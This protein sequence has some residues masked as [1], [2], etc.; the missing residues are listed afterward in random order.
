MRDMQHYLSNMTVDQVQE[1]MALLVE[2]HEVL[3]EPY[4]AR[5]LAW[6]DRE[7][8]RVGGRDR[9]SVV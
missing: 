3:G 1:Y 7:L 8:D 6:A 2:K 5:Q 4:V 9:K